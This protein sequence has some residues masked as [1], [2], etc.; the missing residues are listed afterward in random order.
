MTLPQPTLDEGVPGWP[1]IIEIDPKVRLD[2]KNA[3]VDKD[4]AAIEI[5]GGSP[6]EEEGSTAAAAAAAASAI[7]GSLLSMAS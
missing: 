3:M 1:P 2:G 6:G 4:V 7:L 5:K